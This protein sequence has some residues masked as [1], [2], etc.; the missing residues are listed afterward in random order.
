[1]SGIVLFA[2]VDGFGSANTGGVLMSVGSAV[3]AALYKVNLYN[4]MQNMCMYM[5]IHVCPHHGCHKKVVSSPDS[6]RS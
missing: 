2:Y 6:P 4:L 3:G 1:M 5:Y